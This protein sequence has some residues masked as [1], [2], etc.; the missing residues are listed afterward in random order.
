MTSFFVLE[1][2]LVALETQCCFTL[3]SSLRALIPDALALLIGV[4][5]SV[6]ALVLCALSEPL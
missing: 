4:C 3:V 2:I 1:I 5:L 6:I